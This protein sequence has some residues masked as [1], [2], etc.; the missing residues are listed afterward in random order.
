MHEGDEGKAR[1]HNRKESRYSIET[2][3]AIKAIRAGQVMKAMKAKRVTTIAK[4]HG[5]V[6]GQLL[7]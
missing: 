5:T 1:D 7:P 4:N 3:V 6:L 2:V